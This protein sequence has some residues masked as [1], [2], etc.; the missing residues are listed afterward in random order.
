M[1]LSSCKEKM[2]PLIVK[3]GVP[4]QKFRLPFKNTGNQDLE[5]E[6]TFSK[7]SAVIRGPL[8]S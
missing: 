3:K 4:G 7:Q 8:K 6:F 2:I 1:V 5:L